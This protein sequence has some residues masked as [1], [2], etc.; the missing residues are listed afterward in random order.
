MAAERGM[1]RKPTV[2][3]LCTHNTARS[4]MAEALLRHMAGDRFEVASAGLEPTNVH[5]LTRR[6]L[7]E[8]G[9]DVG[10]LRAKGVGEF[11]GKRTVHYAIIVCSESEW[12]CPRLFP[13][14]V[15]KLRWPFEDPAESSGSE[16]QRLAVFRRV[17]DAIEARLHAWLRELSPRS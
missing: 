14:A 9:L 10:N 16:A 8:A 11:L 13:F 12:Q 4:Q 1:N 6:V 3:F 7:V 5:P 2:L 17:R 15:A